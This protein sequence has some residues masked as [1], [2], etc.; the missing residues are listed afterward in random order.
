MSFK[1]DLNKV[2][3]EVQSACFNSYYRHPIPAYSVLRNKVLADN[4]MVFCGQYNTAIQT[5]YWAIQELYKNGVETID[6]INITNMLNSNK[7]VKK[8]IEEYTL[9]LN[10]NMSKL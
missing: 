6:A 7:A 2:V 9:I 3:L 8:K 5:I 4:S 1:R 10:R